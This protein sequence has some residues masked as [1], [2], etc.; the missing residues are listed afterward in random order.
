MVY[1]IK[2]YLRKDNIALIIGLILLVSVVTYG[3]HY[4]NV[5]DK[6]KNIPV[7]EDQ[8]ASSEICSAEGIECLFV[9]CNGFF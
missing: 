3:A 1:M 8:E 7:A 4:S 5:E 9:G 6:T 2:K